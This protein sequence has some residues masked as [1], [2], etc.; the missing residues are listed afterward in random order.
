MFHPCNLSIHEHSKQWVSKTEINNGELGFIPWEDRSTILA[1]LFFL[2]TYWDPITIKNPTFIYV[3]NHRNGLQWITELF[4]N[5][6]FH[7]YISTKPKNV[8]KTKRIVWREIKELEKYYE[9]YLEINESVFLFSAFVPTKKQ[10]LEDILENQMVYI[11]EIDP[12]H[13]WFTFGMDQTEKGKTMKYLQGFIYWKIW[14]EDTLTWLKP[15]RKGDN[16][17]TRAWDKGEYKQWV[18]Y[19]Y[20]HG[21]RVSYNNPFTN[22]PE[23][24][25]KPYL[26]NDFDDLAEV[27]VL[28][29]YIKKFLGNKNIENTK[30]KVFELSQTITDEINKERGLKEKKTLQS[31]RVVTKELPE[32]PFRKKLASQKETKKESVNSLAP[33]V[34]TEQKLQKYKKMKEALEGI[35]K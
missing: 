18:D 9:D 20:T 27:S 26:M 34:P 10:T 30:E 24:I 1:I 22:I 3:G 4:P 7:F 31:E 2:D 12:V 13:A 32:D 5:I 6:T 14:A 21:R 16:Y 35:K 8:K 33:L 25:H 19:Q 17:Y 23:A 29:M 15:V 28:L 11:D